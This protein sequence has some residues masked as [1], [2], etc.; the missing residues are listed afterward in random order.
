MQDAQEQEA[1][2]S[3]IRVKSSKKAPSEMAGIAF[4]S[5]GA[6]NQVD[7]RAAMVADPI[8]KTKPPPCG[9]STFLTKREC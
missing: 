6:A 7:W 2:R 3:M 5:E 8:A 1:S 4:V 9:G